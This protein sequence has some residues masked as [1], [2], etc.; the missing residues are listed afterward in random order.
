MCVAEYEA[1]FG[2]SPEASS[3]WFGTTGVDTNGRAVPLP[4]SAMRALSTIHV[5]DTRAYIRQPRRTVV[6]ICLCLVADKWGR[7]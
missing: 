3:L 2:R 5:D 6:L 4:P 1:R 7:H